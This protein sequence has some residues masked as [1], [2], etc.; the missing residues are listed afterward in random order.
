MSEE[1]TFWF[2]LWGLALVFVLALMLSVVYTMAGKRQAMLEMVSKGADPMKV[3]CALSMHDDKTFCIIDAVKEKRDEGLC[4][5]GGG[6]E[7]PCRS[8]V[9]EVGSQ[10]VCGLPVL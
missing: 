8:V 10:Q 7:H 4:K 6:K 2:R 9:E 1:G 5:V 3:A